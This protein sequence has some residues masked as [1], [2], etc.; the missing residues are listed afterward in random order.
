MQKIH[1]TLAKYSV[2]ENQ[3]IEE[4]T[5]SVIKLFFSKSAEAAIKAKNPS[6]NSI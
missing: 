6:T 1:I 2:N 4:P 3:W 5:D